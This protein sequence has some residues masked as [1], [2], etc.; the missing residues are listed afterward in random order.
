MGEADL[1]KSAQTSLLHEVLRGAPVPRR[2]T[3]RYH[4]AMSAEN[5]FQI[6]NASVVPFW[7]LIAIAPG[8]VW[9]RRI[10]HSV[11]APLLFGGLYIALLATLPQRPAGADLGSLGGVAA[12]FTQPRAL[13][14]GWV[15]YIV[16]DLFVGA[17]I[18][19][20][21]Q[22]RKI[23][24]VIVFPVLA[25]TLMLGPSGLMAYLLLR[26]ALRRTATLDEALET[27]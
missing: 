10:V 11:L 17:W 13:L 25:L 8:W 15:H 12:L 19:R 20:D 7:L 23:N 1:V 5:L 14:A 4:A 21:A 26:G 22:R 24:R 2:W 9:T 27:P 16:F 3:R 6:V 18:A